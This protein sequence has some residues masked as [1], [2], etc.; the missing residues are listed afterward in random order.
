MDWDTTVGNE[1][2]IQFADDKNAASSKS[3]ILLIQD[4]DW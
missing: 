1:K 2:E 3:H 4:K